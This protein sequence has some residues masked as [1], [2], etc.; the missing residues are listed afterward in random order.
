M[1]WGKRK[2]DV[3]MKMILGRSDWNRHGG[4]GNG[5]RARGLCRPLRFR[6]SAHFAW[7]KRA[8]RVQEADKRSTT[9]SDI[10]KRMP[11]GEEF[12]LRANYGLTSKRSFE[13]SLKVHEMSPENVPLLA[14]I[15][16][17]QEAAE[18]ILRRLICGMMGRGQLVKNADDVNHKEGKFLIIARLYS[19]VA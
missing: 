17:L 9:V 11:E 18:S 14:E 2:S 15:K 1:S 16:D 4:G 12:D 6:K 19:H 13:E 5:G 8:I 7:N 10:W 3:A